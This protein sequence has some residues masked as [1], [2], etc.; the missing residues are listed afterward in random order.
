MLLQR[1]RAMTGVSIV[2]DVA[3]HAGRTDTC[4]AADIA[5]RLGLARRGIEPVL[6]ALTRA[7]LLE[8]VRR[9]GRRAIGSGVGAG[10]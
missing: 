2:L 7:G 3:L 10:I 9:A 1:D 5:E 8:S 6:Q 4:S